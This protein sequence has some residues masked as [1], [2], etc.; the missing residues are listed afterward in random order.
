[1]KHPILLAALLALAIGC[2]DDG[3]CKTPGAVRINGACNCPKGYK[4]DKS[5][6]EEC[7]STASPNAGSSSSSSSSSDAGPSSDSGSSPDGATASV[8]P[9]FA[10][11]ATA[12]TAHVD[13]GAPAPSTLPG[14]PAVATDAASTLPGGGFDSG[15]TPQTPPASQVP[16]TSG[17][18]A[19]VAGPSDA[20]SPA[21]LVGTE[22]C[23]GKDNDC[24]G[25]IDEDN[26][27]T[28]AP[29]YTCPAGA[30]AEWPMPD[31]IPGAK[32]APKYTVGTDVVTDE[33]TKLV[34]QRNMPAMPAGCT[35][36]N[37]GCTQDE[38]RIY[39]DSLTLEGASDW[40]LPT[41]IELESL[42]DDTRGGGST[43]T[44]DPEFTSPK[45]SWRVWTASPVVF[46]TGAYWTVEFADGMTLATLANNFEY[47]LPRCVR[48]GSRASGSRYLLSDDVAVDNWTGLQWQRKADLTL[49]GWQSAV[50]RCPAL[51]QGFRLPT[52]K[53]L[54][55][56]VD[57]SRAGIPLDPQ[58]FPD[59]AQAPNDQKGY[60][61][62]TLVNSASF[63]GNVAFVV[64]P[65][66]TGDS[67]LSYGGSLP[68]AIS[69][70]QA[71]VRCVR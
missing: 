12:P 50:A 58:V 25:A 18:D 20:A 30:C 61:S 5:D 39:C 68:A 8:Q 4:L 27:C 55:T 44:H 2:G 26:V 41:K 49:T 35:S 7:V 28:P 52:K 63:G 21:C 29:V 65:S 23:D 14:Q 66:S 71:R 13:S 16:N 67:T 45:G 43:F 3:P 62:S 48:G 6:G 22:A 47:K 64:F 69:G 17:T 59:A 24:D 38:A 40:R 70:D 33:I 36:T 42:V 60:W 57:A 46:A 32:V 34:W 37:G 53:E 11:D 10:T 1:M 51:G 19:A 54:L 15:S 56:L 9:A 31:S